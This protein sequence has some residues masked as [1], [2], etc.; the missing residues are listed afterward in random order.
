MA[1]MSSPRSP[2]SSSGYGQTT[3]SKKSSPV[4][5]S[6]MNGIY[7]S[8]PKSPGRNENHMTSAYMYTHAEEADK[9]W[10]IGG[11]PAIKLKQLV[12][13]PVCV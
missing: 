2:G 4:S 11:M 10:K 3:P 7:G 1:N 12:R 5:P 13:R 9:F 8:S 6:R